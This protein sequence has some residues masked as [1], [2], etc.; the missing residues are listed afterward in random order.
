MD[1]LLGGRKK[2]AAHVTGLLGY[3]N[4]TLHRAAHLHSNELNSLADPFVRV[5]PHLRRAALAWCLGSWQGRTPR[6]VDGT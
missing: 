3:L 4:V 1:W 2:E 6:H 5:P